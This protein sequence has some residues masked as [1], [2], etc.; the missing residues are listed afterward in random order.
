VL[1]VAL[2]LEDRRE[3]DDLYIQYCYAI[4]NGDVD[5]WV[6]CFA[7]DGVFVPSFGPVRGEFRGSRQ[8]GEFAANAE[9]HTTTRHW[10][11]N[12]FPWTDEEPVSSTCYG[13]VLDYS[14]PEPLVMVHVVYHDLLVREGGRW[15]FLER[16]PVRDAVVSSA[17]V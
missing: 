5:G 1:T 10:N 8:L 12:V 16:R 3:I 11:A 14:R 2:S 4:N 15:R 7:R 17:N 9:R 6:A 13:I